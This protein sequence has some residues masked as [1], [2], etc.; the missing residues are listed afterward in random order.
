MELRQE[1]FD[2]LY[3]EV[4]AACGPLPAMRSPCSHSL[5]HVPTERLLQ[6]IDD[7]TTD[8]PW[9]RSLVPGEDHAAA[10]EP[11]DDFVEE[12][13]ATSSTIPASFTVPQQLLPYVVKYGFEAC[14]S[15]YFEFVAELTA[16]NPYSP[17]KSQKGLSCDFFPDYKCKQSP[18]PVITTCRKVP[19]C[20]L[21]ARCGSLGDHTMVHCLGC[22][23]T[24]HYFCTHLPERLVTKLTSW[25][26]HRCAVCA[27]CMGK[28]T[29]GK[30]FVADIMDTC[31]RCQLQYHVNCRRINNFNL[32]HRDTSKEMKVCN[33]CLFQ[34]HC[35]RCRCT[36]P[37]EGV[38]QECC[39]VSSQ[40]CVECRNSE[41]RDL[42]RPCGADLKISLRKVTCDNCKDIYHVDCLCDTDRPRADTLPFLCCDCL[43]QLSPS[44]TQP[45]ST[46][47]RPPEVW[48]AK[49]G[50]QLLRLLRGEI[51]QHMNSALNR[52]DRSSRRSES[53]RKYSP[54]KA[55][56]ADSV[57]LPPTEVEKAAKR[58]GVV[59]RRISVGGGSDQ[60]VPSCSSGDLGFVRR[61]D[62]LEQDLFEAL[63]RTGGGHTNADD[64]VVDQAS[65]MSPDSG[66]VVCD[67]AGPTGACSSFDSMRQTNA[68]QKPLAPSSEAAWFYTKSGGI[69]QTLPA[70][71]FGPPGS[72]MD[73]PVF[74]CDKF[75]VFQ[76]NIAASGDSDR[77]S[78][79]SEQIL[80]ESAPTALYT[81]LLKAVDDVCDSICLD[82][83]K[84]QAYMGEV[85]AAAGFSPLFIQNIDTRFAEFC[86]KIVLPP[87]GQTQTKDAIR[88]TSI[89][90][91]LRRGSE[92]PPTVSLQ[93]RWAQQG[94]L[95]AS[96]ANKTFRITDL[97]VC[98]FCSAAGDDSNSAGRLLSVGYDV[99][100]HIGC[101]TFASTKK[102][103]YDYVVL[104]LSHLESPQFRRN[105]CAVC[106]L[107]LAVIGCA[108]K[109]CRN[110]YHINCAALEECSFASCLLTE[111]PGVVCPVHRHENVEKEACIRI[112]RAVDL[113][114]SFREMPVFARSPPTNIQAFGN[115]AWSTGV[116]KEDVKV[117]LG[118]AYIE[119]LGRLVRGWETKDCLLPC[120]Y[121][122]HRVFWSSVAPQRLTRY[123]FLTLD[124]NMHPEVKAL[125]C[126]ILRMEDI[127]ALEYIKQRKAARLNAVPLPEVAIFGELWGP[128]DID[129]GSPPQPESSRQTDDVKMAALGDVICLPTGPADEEDDFVRDTPSAASVEFQLGAK[130]LASNDRDFE[131]LF[132][133][134]VNSDLL[135][136]QCRAVR[137]LCCRHERL[138][139]AEKRA[140]ATRPLPCSAAS[141]NL[142]AVDGGCIL[143]FSTSHRTRVPDP[144]GAAQQPEIPLDDSLPPPAKLSHGA[145][146]VDLWDFVLMA[147]F[148]SGFFPVLGRDHRASVCR[149]SPAPL[150]RRFSVRLLVDPVGVRV[151]AETVETRVPFVVVERPKKRLRPA[152]GG[153]QTVL[154][155]VDVD[156]KTRPDVS[157]DVEAVD[158]AVA[159]RCGRTTA[160]SGRRRVALK[161]PVEGSGAGSTGVA[162][163]AAFSVISS[164]IPQRDSLD[165]NP[166]PVVARNPPGQRESQCLLLSCFTRSAFLPGM[167]LLDW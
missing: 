167:C 91:V 115:P 87:D 124:L 149:S 23:D 14:R 116:R 43:I 104:K 24:F 117:H 88:R 42:C 50:R 86:S 59:K 36:I 57:Q 113:D 9:Q 81:S 38:Y 141:T 123:T 166:H 152:G 97:R 162:G 84:L 20:S 158:M 132:F 53:P 96:N 27:V 155:A 133:G 15:V 101:L 71:S 93:P 164:F 85:I 157:Q 109:R 80:H 138:Y 54:T 127:P 11:V 30:K 2:A 74:W 58:N 7:L 161:K 4:M 121:K 3:R 21:C 41:E 145:I 137:R 55:P 13:F 65:Q 111:L 90:P 144:R 108:E 32:I 31:F 79:I 44:C 134:K 29:T 106:P 17:S 77:R 153:K 40:V 130:R 129:D 139:A 82:P 148:F 140:F 163:S 142:P 37:P 128:T 63:A 8:R 120:G 61:D 67:T 122:M 76:Q 154:R 16:K 18:L 102:R 46:V 66:I 146:I 159:K 1:H 94:S 62:G 49:T 83:W 28:E 68:P 156:E 48:T 34:S 119:Q 45:A 165:D 5:A 35:K 72:F 75:A 12:D 135:D 110:S 160:L 151:R 126:A 33:A 19:A 73:D 25:F 99:F 95:P 22:C 150:D 103:V 105:E 136:Y 89:F 64:V 26:C 10:F 114:R 56:P 52:S 147:L 47:I 107:P 98:L 69:P 118:A 39:E 131:S 112:V 70:L 100:A 78:N 92:P 60:A 143:G 51:L 125:I 6:R